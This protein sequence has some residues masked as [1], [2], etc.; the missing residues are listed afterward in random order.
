[1]SEGRGPEESWVQHACRVLKQQ[2]MQT[3][4]DCG[5]WWRTCSFFCARQKNAWMPLCQELA[6]IQS[7]REAS[8]ISWV[9]KHPEL[10]RDKCLFLVTTSGCQ[11]LAFRRKEASSCPR[12]VALNFTWVSKIDLVTL[13]APPCRVRCP[14]SLGSC[15]GDCAPGTW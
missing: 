14:F 5:L 9:L 3:L 12:L 15:R 1:M 7:A 11:L 4:A 13:R 10:L 8:R 6:E 2:P